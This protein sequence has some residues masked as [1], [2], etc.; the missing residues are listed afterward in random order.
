MTNCAI[1]RGTDFKEHMFTYVPVNVHMYINMYSAAYSCQNYVLVNHSLEGNKRCQQNFFAYG[2]EVP[3]KY[4]FEICDIVHENATA[5][6]ERIV[7][8]W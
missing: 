7:S 3:I 2:I 4:G 5:A 8:D 6:F 1:S